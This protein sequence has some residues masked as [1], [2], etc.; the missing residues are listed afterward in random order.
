M[1]HEAHK[2]IVEA[3][4]RATG[5][6]EEAVRPTISRPKKEF[7]D[8][9]S[10]IAFALAKKS[11]ENPAK[12]ATEICKRISV[13]K[14]ISKAVSQGPFINFFLGDGFLLSV[15][16]GAMEKAAKFGT[17]E[18]NGR[19][20]LVEFP[21]VN[22]NKPWHIGHLRNALLG[23]SVSNILEKRGFLVERQDY[24]DDLGLQVAQSLWGCMNLPAKPETKF[25]H[26]LGQQYVEVSKMFESGEIEP[27]VRKLLQ[28]L[29]E[30]SSPLSK[31][32]R[33]IVESCVL[34]QYQTAFSY[35]VFHDV[36]VFESDIVRSIFEEGLGIVKKSPGV[37]LESSGKNKGCL[38]VRLKGGEF[39]KME[40]PDKILVRS[41]GTA[42][43]TGKDV[44]FQLWKFGKLRKNFCYVKFAMQ[45]NGK[46]ALKTCGCS[47][48]ASDTRFGN[49]DIVV[50]VIGMEQSYPQKSIKEVLVQLGFTK[51]AQNS[52]HLAYGHAVLPEG[53]FSGRQGTWMGY[54]ADELL[55]EGAKRAYKKIHKDFDEA[56][57][58]EIAKS[59]ALGAIRFSFL[60]VSPEKRIVFDW[61][62]A[63][64]FEGDSGPYLMY[65][66]ARM[67][68][69]IKKAA[70]DTGLNAWH[71]KPKAAKPSG[72]A[73]SW[74]ERNLCRLVLD[75]ENA[76]IVS[77]RDLKP[78]VI[79]D[80]CLELATAFNKF[81][82]TS[83]IIG[84]GSTEASKARMTMLH[85]AKAALE[86]SMGI[87]GIPIIK[88]M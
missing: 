85:G 3:L 81:Y 66:V 30:P 58:L 13:G 26:W 63:L 20:A 46:V 42:T 17:E 34:A 15:C 40:N 43:Y 45:P 59:V 76:L 29:E 51:E 57:K 14:A 62:S 60:K 83:R 78:H 12:L 75:Y 8:F 39:D 41:D 88:E 73:L 25:D 37:A 64:S 44:V 69:I 86:N 49:A 70:G 47:Q 1:Y 74:Q 35:G 18:K 77:G 38:V 54:T 7:G 21:S 16:L 71:K 33:E 53:S 61:E 55:E 68:S 32:S 48:G 67:N 28:K 50:N 22:P 24:I 4:C 82:D 2:Q 11:G 5:E 80:Y 79:A 19:K 27:Q 10:S 56:K 52:I 65:C 6:S 72:Y 87:L 31:K 9:A 23:D 84:E 36:L